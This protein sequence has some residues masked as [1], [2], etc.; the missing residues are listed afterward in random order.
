MNDSEHVPLPGTQA[1]GFLV[2]KHQSSQAP[3]GWGLTADLSEGQKWGGSGFR[4]ENSSCDHSG[5]G[6][7]SVAPAVSA[8][9]TLRWL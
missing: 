4:A 8:A 9:R 3:R 1:P 6:Q 5:Y 2:L 7:I